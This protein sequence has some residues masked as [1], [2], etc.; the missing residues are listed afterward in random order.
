MQLLGALNSLIG[1]YKNSPLLN[2]LNSILT[3]SQNPCVLPCTLVH[4]LFGFWE[5]E[6]KTIL[7]ELSTA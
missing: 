2:I 4:G 3:I 7:K 6:Q 1:E 5:T